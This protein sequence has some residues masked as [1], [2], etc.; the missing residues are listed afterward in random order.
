M[1]TNMDHSLTLRNKI[2]LLKENIIQWEDNRVWSRKRVGSWIGSLFSPTVLDST[3][4][5]VEIGD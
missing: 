1:G 5:K 4:R 2:S 3:K